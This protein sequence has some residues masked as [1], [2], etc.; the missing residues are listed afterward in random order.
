[1]VYAL[2]FAPNGRTL[3]TSEDCHDPSVVRLWWLG[4]SR[5]TRRATL[6][7]HKNTV[8]ALAFAPDGE[9]LASADFD[10]RLFLWS[11]DGRR[12]RDWQLPGLIWR[13]AFAPDSRHLATANRNGTIYIL[14]LIPV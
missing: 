5:P 1:S 10:G 6:E 2:A 4:G 8:Q 3:A 7:G 13:I 11:A 12:L 14:R 9:T